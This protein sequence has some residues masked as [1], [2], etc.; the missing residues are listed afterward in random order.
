MQRNIAVGVLCDFSFKNDE[1][2][3][4]VGRGTCDFGP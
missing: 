1:G 3:I 4:Y 2:I